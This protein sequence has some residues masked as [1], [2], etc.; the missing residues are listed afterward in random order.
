MGTRVRKT[1]SSSGASARSSPISSMDGSPGEG[2]R[3]ADLALRRDNM[4]S[5]LVDK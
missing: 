2:S 5:I 1:G 4:E 3:R